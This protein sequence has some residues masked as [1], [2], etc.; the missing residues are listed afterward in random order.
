MLAAYKI[1]RSVHLM[2][3]AVSDF[4]DGTISSWL[5]APQIDLAGLF[6]LVRVWDSSRRPEQVAAAMRHF[7]LTVE[8]LPSGA[9]VDLDSNGPDA[10]AACLFSFDEVWIGRADTKW[11][12]LEDLPPM[13]SEA[14]NFGR[15]DATLFD[16][17][18]LASGA[19]V[20]MGDG[21]GLNIVRRV[22]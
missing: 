22:E 18:L 8:V 4:Q 13:T 17:A 19:L 14:V 11:G 6:A 9:L 12:A 7:G 3:N 10:L 5:R 20:G 1:H 2:A 21:C 16:A 15:D